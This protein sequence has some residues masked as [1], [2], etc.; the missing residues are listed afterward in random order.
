[1]STITQDGYTGKRTTSEEVH[2]DKLVIG[3]R[4]INKII[5]DLSQSTQNDIPSAMAFKAYLEDI[6]QKINLFSD[7]LLG[8]NFIPVISD[9]V[10]SNI[11][12]YLN[13]YSER[14]YFSKGIA[15][16]KSE[17]P[18]HVAIL[19]LKDNAFTKNGKYLTTIKVDELNS[20]SIKL[21]LD[22][23]EILSITTPG[24][25]T[26][27]F[28]V[29]HYEVNKLTISITGVSVNDIVNISNINTCYVKDSLTNYLNYMIEYIVT[30]GTGSATLGDIDEAVTELDT[31]L[32]IYTNTL[33]SALNTLLNNHKSAENPHNITPGLIN[34]SSIDH[35]HQNY[36]AHLDSEANPHN[37]N[38]EQVGLGN[39]PNE[40]SDA[41]DI[42]STDI[43][44]TARAVYLLRELITQYDTALDTFQ[45]H[46]DSHI[47]DTE[48][49]HEVTKDQVGLNN[50][51]NYPV[52]DEFDEYSNRTDRYMTP[53]ITQ[54][55]FKKE[56]AESVNKPVQLYPT[57]IHQVILTNEINPRSI[58]IIQGRKYH[59]D[60][61]CLDTE[62]LDNIGMRLNVTY[63]DPEKLNAFL[64]YMETLE[65]GEPV[66]D[67]YTVHVDIADTST[68]INY[69]SIIEYQVDLGIQ[70]V[71][72][73][74][75]NNHIKFVMQGS[76]FTKGTGRILLNTVS[77]LMTGEFFCYKDDGEIPYPIK[78]MTSPSKAITKFLLSEGVVISGITFFPID[79][80]IPLNGQIDIFELAHA[81]LY[82]DQN[83][84]DSNPIGTILEW[85]SNIPPSGYLFLTGLELDSNEYESLLTYAIINNLTISN[86]DYITALTTDGF[87]SKFGYDPASP[88]LFK[89]PYY[90]TIQGIRK[91][92]KTRDFT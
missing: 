25:Y 39:L 15:N 41:I 12:S 32:R 18:S 76:P 55:L 74:V 36:Q 2:T 43:L 4:F 51:E 90:E 28:D 65:V 48:N 24:T 86:S 9:P 78:L 69:N 83:S 62:C 11:P 13:Y 3:D 6:S 8:F 50:I 87:C 84:I 58:D 45:L 71:A 75:N 33:V 53:Y 49:P 26:K 92:I 66:I 47:L 61:K 16:Y 1:M 34:A 68:I 85:L 52:A 91:M 81:G 57:P 54:R 79:E 42:D 89:L 56:L 67:P 64:A 88:E 23:T 22:T 14:I 46:I 37:V 70:L 30:G 72:D 40:K 7:K 63:T 38:K 35:T 17:D 20:G 82:S 44:A 60:I 10:V 27:V 21:L 77:M 19:Q 59:I 73:H 5:D 31:S 80:L 29:T